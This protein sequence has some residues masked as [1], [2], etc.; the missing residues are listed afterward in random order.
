MADTDADIWVCGECRSI[1]NLRSKQCY[2]C[3]TPRDF[4]AVDPNQ[5]E[6]TGHG[7]LREIALPEFQ[8]TRW[9][10][11]LASALL[12]L[13][14]V[15]QVVATVSDA[16]LFGRV[17]RNPGL[18]ND[19]AFYQ[20]VESMVAG[21]VQVATLGIALLALIA[22][23]FW[24]S[25]AV[26]AM[27]A[28][29]LGYPAANGLMAFLEN[30]LPG[31]NLFRVPAIV[32]DVMRRLDPGSLRGEALIFAAWIGL[33]G[34]YLV[35]RFGAYLGLL[36]SGTLEEIVRETLLVQGIATALVVVGATFLVALIWWIERRIARRRAA[37][38][39]GELPPEAAAAVPA[40]AGVSSEGAS[41]ASAAPI[42][43]D[44]AAGP[45]GTI[46]S[47]AESSTFT[48]RS[49]TAATGAASTPLEAPAAETTLAPTPSAEAPSAE[50]P[51]AEAP[52][53][54]APTGV[55]PTTEAPLVETPAPLEPP[56]AEQ[57]PPP[58]ED[59]S[60]AAEPSSAAPEPAVDPSPAENPEPSAAEPE[61]SVE[62][63]GAEADEPVPEPPGE[64]AAGPQLHLSVE[65]A[66]SMIA[67][68]DGESESIAL[69]ELRVAAEALAKANGSAVI[70]TVG[71]SFGA[72]SLAEQAFEV[73]EDA[74]VATTIEE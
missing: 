7:K 62:P 48:S 73:L 14:A 43:E 15:T 20:S 57:A 60:V 26:M 19:P 71:T 9:A 61:P 36:G 29:G 1:N 16:I 64:A 12:I 52:A 11:V 27:P 5:I 30:F 67:T 50:T 38:L 23:S 21:T 49:I 40:P 31:L 47:R 24:L 18:L 63:S 59:S 46:A 13:V 58:A 53:A 17:L 70:E 41:V 33:L 3:R 8:S 35:P 72:L 37:Q 65:S 2:R 54:E 69:D 45:L 42:L 4:A 10:A 25:R 34:G 66:S 44:G 6:G 55:A 51:S 32:R 39:A 28:L 68:M 74:Q 56:R 22:W